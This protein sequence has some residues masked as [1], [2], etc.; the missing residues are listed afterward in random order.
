MFV[1]LLLESK[2][3][4]IGSK[5]KTKNEY[6]IGKQAQTEPVRQA[7]TNEDNQES[8]GTFNF[9]D[10]SAL[11]EKQAPLIIVL[12]MY[13]VKKLKEDLMGARGTMTLGST[14]VIHQPHT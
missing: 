4:R 2:V 3:F 9:D 11:Q 10:G 1:C 13:L 5:K 7:G 6:K 14:T 8:A 12:N